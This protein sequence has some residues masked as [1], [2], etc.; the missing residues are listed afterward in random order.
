M[1]YIK[2]KLPLW[3]GG[4][5]LWPFILITP[6]FW[7][8]VTVRRHEGIHYRQWTEL[9]VVA[10]AVQIVLYFAFDV[11]SFW[12]LL[13]I[14][15]LSRY[16]WYVVEFI[17]RLWPLIPEYKAHYKRYNRKNWFWDAWEAA[18]ECISLEVEATLHQYDDGYLQKGGR[19]HFAWLKYINQPTPKL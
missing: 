14:G 12:W 16:I 5:T 11:Y 17:V 4:I 9:M 2:I 19:K 13:A 10:F 18:Y 8:S 7:D 1:N 6:E 15:Y 3:L